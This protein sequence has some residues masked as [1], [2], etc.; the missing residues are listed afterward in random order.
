V[1]AGVTPYDAAR[2]IVPP[3]M[4][5]LSPLFKA[6]RV[7]LSPTVSW[8]NPSLT[9]QISADIVGL[10]TGQKTVDQALADVDAKWSP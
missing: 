10:F 6:G 3:L 9:D 1:T 8:P 4:A 7:M 5:P 2:G